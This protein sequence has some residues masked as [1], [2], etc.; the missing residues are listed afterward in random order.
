MNKKVIATCAVCGAP[1][2]RDSGYCSAITAP[3]GRTVNYLYYCSKECLDKTDKDLAEED[4]KTRHAICSHCKKRIEPGDIIFIL[5]HK[6][7]YCSPK[8]VYYDYTPNQ[9]KKF[10]EDGLGRWDIL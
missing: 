9:I 1:V 4:K 2:Y 6:H 3:S 7:F 8:C 10:Q 5:N